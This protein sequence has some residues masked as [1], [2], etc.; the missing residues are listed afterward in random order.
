MRNKCFWIFILFFLIF[1]TFAFAITPTD[2]WDEEGRM[3]GRWVINCVNNGRGGW[4]GEG[5]VGN[6]ITGVLDVLSIY[7]PDFMSRTYKNNTRED[8]LDELVLY[9]KNNPKKRH[10]KVIEV[11]MSGCK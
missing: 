2:E 3:N 5:A 11:I 4:R 7:D 9:Y 1:H 6:Y 10:R 8:I